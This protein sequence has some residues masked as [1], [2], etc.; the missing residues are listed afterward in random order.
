MKTCY[1][2]KCIKE[3]VEF[4]KD[5]TKP[6]GLEG[7][8]KACTK[9]KNA[10]WLKENPAKAYAKQVL[11][12]ARMRACT[13]KWD[14]ELTE[15]VTQEA[16]AL[17]RL[18]RQATG[19]DWHTDHIVPIKGENVCGLHVWNNLQVIPAVVNIKKGNKWQS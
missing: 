17:I 6:D 12:D 4:H 14:T 15:L 5:R 18:R 8:C 11:R 10:K 13:V 9:I 1:K 2:C 7:I 16:G 3:K 19:I